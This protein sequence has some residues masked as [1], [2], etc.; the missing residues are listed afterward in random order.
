MRNSI[1]SGVLTRISLDQ[2]E[3]RRAD[4]MWLP[5]MTAISL[6]ASQEAVPQTLLDEPTGPQ[7]IFNEVTA[8][9]GTSTAGGIVTLLEASAESALVDQGVVVIEPE[10]S[11]SSVLLVSIGPDVLPA[12]SSEDALRV[13]QRWLRKRLPKGSA[14]GYARFEWRRGALPPGT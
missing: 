8:P 4:E 12:S 9:Y 3:V 10:A 1:T 14:G 13:A 11:G 2:V 7:E 6:P 5:L